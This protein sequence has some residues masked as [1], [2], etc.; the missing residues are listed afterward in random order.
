MKIL[1]DMLL[2]KIK[3]L[4]SSIELLIL[5]KIFILEINWKIKYWL[6]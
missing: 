4:K 3:I 2:Y 6:Y 1:W 5:S